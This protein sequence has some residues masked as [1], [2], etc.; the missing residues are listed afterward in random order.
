MRVDTDAFFSTRPG[1]DLIDDCIRLG[2]AFKCSPMEF[3]DLT[4]SQLQIMM[5]HT[6]EV[7]EQQR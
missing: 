3:F 2:L 1:Q 7:L 5:E 6:G 4:F